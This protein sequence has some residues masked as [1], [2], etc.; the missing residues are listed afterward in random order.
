ML[1]FSARK[2]FYL[3]NIT[4]STPTNFIV[5]REI[6]C[7]A[8]QNFQREVPGSVASG[9]Y[10]LQDIIIHISVPH[11]NRIPG[12]CRVSKTL[13]KGPL[14]LGKGNTRQRPLADESIGKGR[15]AE[16]QISG[17]R[18]RLC[19]VSDVRHSANR[20]IFAEC[21]PSDTRQRSEICLV[22]YIWHS[23]NLW[24]LPSVI[25]L[26]LGKSLVFA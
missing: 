21:R 6:S 1:T 16:C 4:E 11:H 13:G 25:Y 3:V 10:T 22:S 20:Q 5:F 26:T 24:S 15:F 12:L 23:A 2:Q 19:R 17:T 18:Q 7:D 8:F 14:A 9:K